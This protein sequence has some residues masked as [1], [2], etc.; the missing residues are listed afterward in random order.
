MEKL[1]KSK[2]GEEEPAVKQN[3]ETDW[4]NMTTAV[5]F[6]S[7]QSAVL[8]TF[9]EMVAEIAS[10][11][12]TVY[13]RLNASNDKVAKEEFLANPSLVHPNNE[14]GYLDPVEVAK[15]LA[16]LDEIDK[17]ITQSSFSEQQRRLLATL[18]DDCRR[19]NDFLAANIE[20][21]AAT[22]PEKKAEAAAHHHNANEALYGKPDEAT[23]Y[24][25][26]KEKL[27]Q[28]DV[29]SLSP[30]DQAKYEGLL[31]KIGPLKDIKAERF[32]PKP[33]TVSHFAELVKEFFGGFLKHL[34]EDQKEFTGEDMAKITNEI[35]SEEFS[36]VPS[37]ETS[38]YHAVVSPDTSNASANHEKRQI[39]FSDSKTYSKSQA[40]GILVH[41]L[42]T[43]VMRAIPYIEQDITAFSTGFP[44]N[45]TFDEG[46]AKCVEQAIQ[47]KYVDSG[48]DHYINIGLATFMHKNFREVYEAQST[49]NDLLGKSNKTL[50]NG[51]QRC[52]RG[53]GELPNNKDLAYYNG[54]NQVWKYIE[55]HIDDPELFDH[56]FLVGKLDI[57]N[58]EQEHLS[59]E[60]RTGGI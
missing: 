27:T 36:D 40:A 33:E 49:L 30:E 57:T 7:E 28:V 22:T 55:E 21:N 14:Y 37:A 32:R 26:L 9:P 39:I 16:T 59:Y 48:V 60:K 41:E 8:T 31:G 42:G 12:L 20:Y 38:S 13:E 43:H 56:L 53:T 45:E 51:V 23:F 1:N 25:L 2:N 44:D 29:G 19:K 11:D 58:P 50:L 52:F 46:V 10:T 34:P 5:P 3:G 35:L 6:A 17:Q 18:S 24:S 4:S 54:A 47:G 15:N